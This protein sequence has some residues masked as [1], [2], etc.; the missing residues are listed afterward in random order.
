LT[1]PLSWLEAEVQAAEWGGHLVTI[2]DREE[3]LWLINNF[4]QQENFWIGLKDVNA[5]E[6]WEWTKIRSPKTY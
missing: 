5:E 3:E 2:N 4:G 6:N 1:E